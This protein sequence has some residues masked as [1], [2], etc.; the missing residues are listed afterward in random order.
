M[1]KSIILTIILFIL[2]SQLAYADDVQQ[3][4]ASSQTTVQNTIQGPG[5]VSSHTESTVNGQTQTLDVNTPGTYTLNNSVP[6]STTS[7]FPKKVIAPVM[8]SVVP[9][10]S[11][12]SGRKI[13]GPFLGRIRQGNKEQIFYLEAINKISGI[14][15]SFF[16]K[17]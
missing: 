10:V 15:K 1:R 5:S 3:G 11:S 14:F 4:A 2:S 6:D 7:N 12:V 8:P 9:S 17:L 16:G 13:P